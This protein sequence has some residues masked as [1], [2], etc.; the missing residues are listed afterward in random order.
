MNRAQMQTW[1][2]PATRYACHP[3]P[4]LLLMVA[5]ASL[6]LPWPAQGQQDDTKW[7]REA[8]RQALNDQSYPW[9]D[10]S[11]DE[12]ESIHVVPAAAPPEAQDWKLNLP[13]WD[14]NAP[15]WN[16]NWRFD[17]WELVQWVITGLLIGVLVA[18]LVYF[19]R[20][21]IRDGGLSWMTGRA[22]N[23]EAIARESEQIENL[24]FPVEAPKADLLAEARYHY[25]QGDFGKAI[26]YLFSYQLVHLD[27]HHLIRLA[28]GKTNR[29]YLRELGHRQGTVGSLL[30]QTMISFEEVFF[31]NHP[32]DRR[33]FEACW[34][35]LDE[36][37]QG[38]QGFGPSPVSGT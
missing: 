13:K 3:W 32:L 16:W 38:V 11:A 26:V 30:Q 29:Q 8:A 31:G 10:A 12:L 23:N 5:T 19:I 24:P 34:Q 1:E 20:T 25:E 18:A 21:V 22:A 36:F 17:F 9:Y 33:R 37:H 14:P 7:G 27:R 6:A 2:R 4:G 28:K 15:N 35:R